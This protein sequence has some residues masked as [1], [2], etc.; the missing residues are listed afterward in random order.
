MVVTLV[1]IAILVALAWPNYSAVKEKALDREA[2]SS[3]ALIRAAEMVYRLEQGFYYPRPA[4]TADIATNINNFLKLSLPET[5]SP[6]PLWSISINSNPTEFATATR[7]G[8]GADG[9]KWSINFSEEKVCPG[10]TAC[11]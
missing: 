2:K 11:P 3:L 9:R 7:T 1:I 6:T 4:G 5:T 8:V 10:G